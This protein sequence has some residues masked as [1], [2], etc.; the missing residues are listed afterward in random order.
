[1]PPSLLRPAA[2]ATASRSVMGCPSPR[3]GLSSSGPMKASLIGKEA[4]DVRRDQRSMAH[5][6]ID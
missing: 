1:M 6:I 5:I 2:L 4:N 3:R